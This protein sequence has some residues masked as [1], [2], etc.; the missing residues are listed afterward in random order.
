MLP[1]YGVC[2]RNQHKINIL[3]LY[4]KE[5]Y[6]RLFNYDSATGVCQLYSKRTIHGSH[7]TKTFE[8]FFY[9]HTNYI[10]LYINLR[11]SHDVFIPLFVHSFLTLASVRFGQLLR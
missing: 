2:M 10:Y 11:R 3:C 9:I 6:K 7:F 5:H 1:Q 4:S 8:F